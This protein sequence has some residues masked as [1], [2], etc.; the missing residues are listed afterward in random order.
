MASNPIDLRRD[1]DFRRKEAERIQKEIDDKQSE[2]A[3]LQ[4]EISEAEKAIKKATY[5][6]EAIEK[7]TSRSPSRLVLE[8]DRLHKEAETFEAQAAQWEK[9]LEEKS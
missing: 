1:A 5:A 3:R 4:N 8:I 9:E 6:K 7:H 2:I